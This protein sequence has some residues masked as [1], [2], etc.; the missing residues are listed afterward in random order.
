MLLSS[1]RVTNFR[2]LASA[3][4][5][6]TA[7]GLNIICGRN[8]SGKTSIL[9]AIYYLG[10]G[11]SFRSST[12]GRLVQQE[13]EQFSIFSQLVSDGQRQLPVGVERHINGTTR[14]RVAEKEATNV[15]E[16]AT[17]L[18]IQLIHSQSHQLFE[19]GPAFRRKYLDWGL[20]YQF[21]NFLPTWRQFERILKQRNAA[22]K[23][24]RPKKEIDAWTEALIIPAITLDKLRRE[25][26]Q[27]LVPTLKAFTQE[28]MLD[29]SID[30]QYQ[31]GWP[32]EMDFHEALIQ[33]FVDDYR[34]G[35]T[36]VGPHR[37]DLNIRIQAIPAKHFLS[38]GQQKLLIC[39]MI[40]AQGSL[41]TNSANK[42]LVYLVDDLPAELDLP[43]R[44]KLISLLSKQKTQVFI[45]AIERET[46][47]DQMSH[48]LNA[49]IRVFHVEHGSIEQTTE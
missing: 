47:D 14:L 10:R 41:L 49:A 18:P 35:H 29:S 43:S 13:T 11:R 48:P 33:H 25:Y 28:L 16:L 8:G 37:A 2:N 4:L 12:V 39:A 46:I 32:D 40:L 30:I 34:Q 24:R 3:A 45:T 20:F 31:S 38:R 9:E 7:H 42:E 15:A 44:M 22:L 26:V 17:L 1:L 36:Q 21:D 6:P 27:L 19:S 5:T 23:N